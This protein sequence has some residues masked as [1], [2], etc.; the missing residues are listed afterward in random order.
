MISEKFAGRTMGCPEF[1]CGIPCFAYNSVPM[2][3]QAK[4]SSSDPA[5]SESHFVKGLQGVVA[6]QTS[7]SLV[8]GEASKLYYRGIPIEELAQQ[9][10]FE[11][12][13]FLLWNGRLPLKPELSSFKSK[14]ASYENIPEEASPILKAFPKNVHPMAALRTLV[15]A[16]GLFDPTSEKIDLASTQLHAFRLTASLPT[17]ISA[18]YRLRQGKI[19]ISPDPKLSFA[20]NFLSMMHGKAPLPEMERALDAYLIL[21]ADHGLNASTFAARVTA[22]TQ[23]DTYS[24][25]TSAIG[26]LKGDLHG[27]ANQRAM[28]MILEIGQPEKAEGYVRNLLAQKK[29][30][31]G[32]GHR[33]YKKEDPRATVFRGIARKLCERT[34]ETKWLAISERVEKVM[35]EEKGIPCNVDFFSASVLYILGFPVDF[36]TT[37]FAASR[38][39]GWT[40]HV[41][42]QRADNRLIRPEADYTGPR[43]RRFIPIEQRK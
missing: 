5:G 19:P 17:I 35:L 18:F 26:T 31:M 36:F 29:K 11:E 20:A 37:V 8:D 23:S 25:V 41:L 13:I 34:G 7:L 15:S 40:A 9:S 32:F 3:P 4:T 12:V 28:E 16:L 2:P 30:V 22:S 10:S 43:G 6:S 24:A 33:I 42:E 21:L 1:A 27:S 14:L 38:V 39:A